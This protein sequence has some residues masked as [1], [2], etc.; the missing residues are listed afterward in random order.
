[1]KWELM[2]RRNLRAVLLGA[3][4]V[5]LLL[6]VAALATRVPTGDV[7]WI[8][9]PQTTEAPGSTIP[10]D[11]RE[12]EEGPPEAQHEADVDQ[13]GATVVNI[14][15]LATFALAVL[16]ASALFVREKAT[17][18]EPTEEVFADPHHRG[19]LTEA[20]SQA[21]DEALRS[22]KAGR[23][24]EHAIIECWRM[25]GHAV[26][27]TDVA[28]DASRTS[29]ELVA[30]VVAST[31]ADAVDVER[32]AELYRQARYSGRLAGDDDVAQATHALA[33]IREALA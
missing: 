2:E 19:T 4:V 29:T 3:V 11:G 23:A 18:T 9:Q 24:P 7:L 27:G 16:V 17:S 22:I 1:M 12:L 15:W 10:G 14:F 26:E 31:Q 20:T 33:A 25:L 21:L 30:A 8:D 13:T 28:A 32:L 5:I 6:V